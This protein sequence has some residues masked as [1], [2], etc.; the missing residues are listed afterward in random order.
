MPA[1]PELESDPSNIS[2]TPG[3]SVLL[4]RAMFFQDVMFAGMDLSARTASMVAT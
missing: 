1:Q 2:E 4:N 3:G